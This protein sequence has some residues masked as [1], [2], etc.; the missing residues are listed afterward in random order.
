MLWGVHRLTVQQQLLMDQRMALMALME[1]GMALKH[2]MVAH[3]VVHQAV[4]HLRGQQRQVQ[5]VVQLMEQQLLVLSAARDHL[6]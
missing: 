3:G 2:L 6:K 4:Q 5:Q 1:P